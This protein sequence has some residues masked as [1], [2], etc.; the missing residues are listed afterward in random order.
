MNQPARQLFYSKIMLF[1]EYSIILNSKALSVPFSHFNGQF[2][3]MNDD[4]YTD[5][6]F[7]E[8]SNR[9]LKGFLNHVERLPHHIKSMFNLEKFKQ[10]IGIGLFFESNIPESYGLGSSGAL[11]AAF[12]TRYAKLNNS[13]QAGLPSDLPQLKILFSQLE[14][15]FHGTSSGIDPLICYVNQ[16]LLLSGNNQIEPVHIPL[17]K[18]EDEDAIFIVNTKKPGKTAPLVEH[19]MDK[20][21]TPEFCDP[22]MNELIPATNKAIDLLLNG[23]LPAFFD[24]LRIIS[25]FQLTHFKEMIPETIRPLWRQGLETGNFY[26]KLCGS[27]GGGF[28]LGFTRQYKQIR[29]EISKQMHDIIPVYH[30]IQKTSI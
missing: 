14:S 9:H 17:K 4:R 3:F 1:G 12:A 2:A 24:V 18:S 22:V 16:P 5:L 10:E 8:Q 30:M 27:G 23:D 13:G 15:Y 6:D 29:H 26:L 19:F 28:V 25:H 20:L 11:V 21:K 7:A